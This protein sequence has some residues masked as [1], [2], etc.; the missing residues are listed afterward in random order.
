MHRKGFISLA[1]T[2]FKLHIK[3][4]I[5]FVLH[6]NMFAVH[7]N[8]LSFQTF[9]PDNTARQNEHCL[10]NFDLS[11]Y[12]QVFSDLAVWIYQALIK[13]MQETVHQMIGRLSL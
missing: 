4:R 6:M 5:V 12:R 8:L 1:I 9:Q 10:R 13:Q 11:E 7:S 3:F 2:L